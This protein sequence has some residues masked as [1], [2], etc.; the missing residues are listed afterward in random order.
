MGDLVSNL[1]LGFGV[2][3]TPV[4]LALAFLGCLVGTLIGVLPGVG[5]IA[6]IAML[7]PITFGLDPV[8]ALIML[9]G[10]YYGA[11]YGGSTTA[12]LVNIPGEATSVVTAL[13]GHQ[14]ARQGRAGVALGIAA[15][16]SFF[17]GTVATLVIAALG[18]PLTGLALIFGPTEY[19][20]LMVM[21]LV[22]AVVLARGS[23][24]KA[25]AM[26][27]V[28]VLLSTVGTDLETGEERMTFGLPFLADGIDFAV[29]AMGIFGIAEIMRNLDHT[30][31]RDVVRQAIGRLLPN[32]DDFKQAY[33]PVLRGTFIGSLLG[34]LPGNGAV[35]G[36]FAA[37]TLEKK[38]AKDP[39]RFGRGAIEGVA[40]PESANN[41]GAQTSFIP[42]LT[43]GIPPNAVMALMVGA[44]TIHGIIPG[45]QVMTKSPTLFWGMIA[46]MWIGNLMLLIINLPLVGMWV[47]LLKVPYRLM[48]PAILMFC[49]IGI[50]SIN[51]LP[52]DVMFIGLFGLM[53]YML[54]KFGFEPAPLL[55]GFVLGR[56]MEE[57]LRRALIISRGDLWTFITKTIPMR[58][59]EFWGSIFNGTLCRPA[60]PAMGGQESPGFVCGYPL[61]ATLL[62][63]AAFVLILALLPSIRKGRDE[64]FTE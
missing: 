52:T 39:Q 62:A 43:L 13:D 44:M 51:S 53:G 17:A 25:I 5:P 16:G 30:E 4:N 37:Y 49:C 63:I 59:S 15:I 28:G 10:I 11:Q 32:M 12:I 56:L 46:S 7:L 58:M 6:T 40:G 50:Y 48:F 36:P 26:I 24:L 57:N 9:A 55:L 47:R 3:L 35:L 22:F 34:I 20:S 27:L 42:L 54:I 31:H 29:L 45:P 60:T 1:S 64:V 8:G 19:F 2:A 14:M 21:G 61:S 41:A 23:I 38:L 33:K 18:A